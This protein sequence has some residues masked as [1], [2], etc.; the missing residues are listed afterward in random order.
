M[1]DVTSLTWDE[2]DDMD[3]NVTEEDLKAAE[4]MGRVS[5]GKYFCKCVGSE[6]KQ[7]D[8]NNYSCIA[9]NLRWEI[10]KVLELNGIPV[11]GDEGETWEGRSIFDD[12]NMAPTGQFANMEKPGMKKRRVLIAKR[13]GLIGSSSDKI[14]K[15][16]WQKDIIGKKAIISYIQEPSW[17]D[18]K[19]QITKPGK[20]KVA[21][22]GYESADGMNVTDQTPSIDDI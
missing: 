15:K 16:M 12:V 8:F 20:R 14:T 4:T 17:V 3:E 6:P 19:T 21:F 1:T 7:Q 11:Q 5:A 18:E 13:T 2:L 9:A 10:Q 22:D